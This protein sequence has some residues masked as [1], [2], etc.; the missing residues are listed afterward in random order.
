MKE[1]GEDLSEIQ[2]DRE[3]SKQENEEEVEN[4]TKLNYKQH[5]KRAAPQ[6]LFQVDT[7]SSKLHVFCIPNKTLKTY[8]VGFTFPE[9]MGFYHVDNCFYIGG[10]K[11]DYSG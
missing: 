6:C 11:F 1:E 8:E 9:G 3:D 10:G 4:V 7:E 5:R 2:G